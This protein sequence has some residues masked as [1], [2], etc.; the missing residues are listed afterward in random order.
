MPYC[1]IEFGG[2]KF[3]KMAKPANVSRKTGLITIVIVC[4]LIFFLIYIVKPSSIANAKNENSFLEKYLENTKDVFHVKNQLS[5][6]HPLKIHAS[7]DDFNSYLLHKQEYSFVTYILALRNSV[8][9]TQLPFTKTHLQAIKDCSKYMKP[10]LYYNQHSLELR[11]PYML[12]LMTEISMKYSANRE[13]SYFDIAW[14]G[15]RSVELSKFN[16]PEKSDQP[17]FRT[18]SAE[19]NVVTAS[20]EVFEEPLF[21]YLQSFVYYIV[22]CSYKPRGK[23]NWSKGADYL[24][25]VA[26]HIVSTPE[27]EENMGTNFISPASHPKSGPQNVHPATLNYFLRQTFLRTD[28]DFTG[29]T[30]KDVIV[31][32]FVEYT[33]NRAKYQNKTVISAKSNGDGL[34]HSE[35]RNRLTANELPHKNNLLV[36]VGSKNP[37]GGLREK[38]EMRFQ[39]AVARHQ[40]E[41]VVFSTEAT[42]H[43]AYKT[44]LFNADFCLS[45][46]GDTASSGRL[47]SVIEAGCIPVLISDWLHLPFASLV[48]Y[49][50]FTL[51]FP[52]SIVNNVDFLIDY[53]RF[54]PAERKLKMQQALQDVR[55]MLLYDPSPADCHVLNPVTLSL[56][57]S[58]LSRKKYCD[59]LVSPEMSPMCRNLLKRLHVA[60]SLQSTGQ[61]K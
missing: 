25:E 53:L 8:K 49:S 10:S 24:Q 54:M 52:E 21:Y 58:L 59:G 18:N 15:N 1:R 55:P 2:N 6:Q 12:S 5:A 40:Y 51:S 36:F 47:F 35:M 29:S 37:A 50:Q 34:R 42:S 44:L 22:Y 4:S 19:N 33:Q 14:R 11:F 30:P 57:E 26:D 23:E 31:P 38:F 20:H 46:R 61:R 39:A 27:W 56:V 28:F 13:S 45:V 48:D 9:V 7:Q 41:D 17:F 32:Y 43:T 60:A 16:T 3:L